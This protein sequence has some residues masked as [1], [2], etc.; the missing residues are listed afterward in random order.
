MIRL[1]LYRLVALVSPHKAA[2]K[3]SVL[4][5]GVYRLRCC[6]VWI[7]RVEVVSSAYQ[8][9]NRLRLSAVRGDFLP[10]NLSLGIALSKLSFLN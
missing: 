3:W 8:K 4:R 7:I 10:N 6:I 2:S 1:R 9:A 5:V